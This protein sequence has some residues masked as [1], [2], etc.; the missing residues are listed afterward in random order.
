[1]EIPLDALVPQVVTF[2]LVVARLSGL[3]I[4]APVFSSAMIPARVKLM[5][6]LV[7]A[8]T[9]TPLVASNVTGIPWSLFSDFSLA[10]TLNRVRNADAM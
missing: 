5:A 6:L 3:F 4:L 8:F 10:P 1:M 2:L 9:M 7:L